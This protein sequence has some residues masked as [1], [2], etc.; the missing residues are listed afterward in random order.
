MKTRERALVRIRA[1]AT[2]FL[3]L[4]AVL[5]PLLLVACGDGDGGGGP[6]Y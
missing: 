2:R 6:A 1:A 5:L 4:G 3:A